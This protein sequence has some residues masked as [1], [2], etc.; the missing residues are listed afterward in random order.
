MTEGGSGNPQ[1]TSSFIPD[2]VLLSRHVDMTPL[3]SVE[4]YGR[5]SERRTNGESHK[6]GISK[7]FQSSA[8]Q[9]GGNLGFVNHAAATTVLH[10]IRRSGAASDGLA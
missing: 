2:L 9:I 10:S 8:S 4:P 3:T 1:G 6:N 5:V 7:T